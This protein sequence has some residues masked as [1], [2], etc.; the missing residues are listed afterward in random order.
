MGVECVGW[1]GLLNRLRRWLDGYGAASRAAVGDFLVATR[2]SPKKCFPGAALD[3]PALLVPAGRSPN[4]PSAE[5]RASGS[6]PD[7]RLP[8]AGAAM[9]GGDYGVNVKTNHIR[10]NLLRYCALC[11]QSLDNSKLRS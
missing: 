11:F 6:T 10:R 4:S 5:K 8:P 3:S 1:R 9:L 2:K 7:S